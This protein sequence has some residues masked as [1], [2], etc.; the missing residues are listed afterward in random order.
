MVNGMVNGYDSLEL[1][2][3]VL[4]EEALKRGIKVEVL[5]W[6]DNFIRLIKDD[7]VELIKQA[8]K[9]S[10]DTY[11]APLIMENKE[12]TKHI[13][14]EKGINVPKGISVKSPEE[15]LLNI[16]IFKEKDLVVKPKST[17]FGKGVVILK[18]LVS[19][20]DLKNAVKFALEYDDTVMIEDFIEGMEYRFLVIDNEVPAILHRVPA[21]VTGDGLKT[22]EQLVV[23]KNK[24]PLRGEGYKT[25]L[26]KIRLG[27]VEKE[28]LALQ[29]K[30]FS[31][32]PQ[33]DETVFLRENSNISTGGDSIDF[34][35]EVIEEY[36][37]LAINAA[38]AAGAKICG[39]D[40]IIDNIKEAP[41]PSN[42]SIIE[43]NFNP[44][45]HIHNFPYKGENRHVER[46]VLKLLGF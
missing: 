18:Q 15:A 10:A 34:T 30:D 21:N 26:E 42:Y 41:N 36:K 2:T 32:V 31:Y 13:L 16:N 14:R 4:I 39:A 8:T 3:Q 28:Y 25:P 5:D 7:K 27:Y 11:I 46:Y 24:D 23:E 22:I 44:A 45:L 37:K 12:I 40:I 29:G 17:N 1:S 20:E 6:N 35:D 33:R 43:L 19:T 38:K 9:T